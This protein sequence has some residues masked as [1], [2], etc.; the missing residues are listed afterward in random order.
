[1][2]DWIARRLIDSLGE[3]DAVAV[4][5]SAAEPAESALRWNPL[6]GPRARPGGRAAAR[7]DPRR[8]DA[9]GLRAVAA[10]SRSRTRGPGR[11]GWRWAR[12]A[13]RSWWPGSSTRGPASA[14]STSAPPRAPRPPTWRRWR[15]GARASRR[16][17]CGPARARGAARP[18]PAHGRRRRGRGGR[19]PRGARCPAATTPC[20]S[21]RPAPA[22]ACSR[23]GRTPAGAA[24]RSRSSRSPRSSATLLARALDAR[25][26]GRPG[27][28]LHLHADRR[29]ERGRRR[30]AGA[31][32]TTS[33]PSTR[34]LAHPRRPEAL[35][36]LPHRHGTDGFFI[37]RMRA[38][39][40]APP[41][42]AGRSCCRR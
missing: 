20:W 8:A 22:W 1:M 33:A 10:R 13:R 17:S 28:L 3:A 12:A 34:S 19:R 39:V 32:S 21:T 41:A 18:R 30:A 16:S 23:R 26:P 36:T 25:A 6:R 14:C 15:A 2:P 37:A 38:A 27:R 11:A 29:G 42:A 31:G 24:A 5:E 35:L 4:M 40:S 7:L 9:R